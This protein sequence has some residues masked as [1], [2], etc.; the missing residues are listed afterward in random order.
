MRENDTNAAVTVQGV[1]IAA[2]AIYCVVLGGTDAAVARTIADFKVG[3]G[4]TSGG[5]AVNVP[6]HD[7]DGRAGVP[8]CYQL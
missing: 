3:G 7:T 5:T 2:R 6:I 4:P 8:H 1:D